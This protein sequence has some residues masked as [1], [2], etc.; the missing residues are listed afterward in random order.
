MLPSGI[1]RTAD[2]SWREG[3]TAMRLAAPSAPSSFV[4]VT[5]ECERQ[6][7]T[8]LKQPS[9]ILLPYLTHRAAEMVAI[10]YVPTACFAP[11]FLSPCILVPFSLVR[12]GGIAARQG[13]AKRE[14]NALLH[15]WRKKL[16]AFTIMHRYQPISLTPLSHLYTKS[17]C[18]SESAI[19]GTVVEFILY[20]E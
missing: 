9:P 16:L 1:G 15:V 14:R 12:L 20:R 18:G 7:G 8:V 5:L 3:S 11:S 19:P 17:I 4:K 2:G 10:S 13:G 6:F